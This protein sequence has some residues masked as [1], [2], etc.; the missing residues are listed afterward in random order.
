MKKKLVILLFITLVFIVVTIFIGGVLNSNLQSVNKHS[1]SGLTAICN[2][3]LSGGAGS[4]TGPTLSW[5]DITM[6]IVLVVISFNLIMIDAWIIIIRA[7]KKT[8]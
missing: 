1:I 8:K 3:N 5:Y 7:R 6:F 4:C 2:T